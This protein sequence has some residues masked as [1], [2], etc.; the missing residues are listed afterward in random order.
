MGIYHVLGKYAIKVNDHFCAT[1]TA[2]SFDMAMSAA[3][4]RRV[5]LYPIV[6]IDILL[7]TVFLLFLLHS[8]F[9]CGSEW[10]LS[11]I[12]EAFALQICVAGRKHTESSE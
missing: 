2:H 10:V 6:V 4:K 7:S 9:Y 3:K 5:A 11:I 1:I 12:I 8:F